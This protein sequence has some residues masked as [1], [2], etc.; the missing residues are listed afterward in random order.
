MT[1]DLLLV[2]GKPQR[3]ASGHM[4]VDSRE[5]HP[6]N[7]PDF[8]SDALQVAEASVAA[9]PLPARLSAVQVASPWDDHMAGSLL[10]IASNMTG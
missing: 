9:Q 10:F 3:L 1:F 8:L 7:V 5:F 4:A 2:N 6:A